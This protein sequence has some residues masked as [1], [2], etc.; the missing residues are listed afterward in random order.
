[1][2]TAHVERGSRGL[3]VE[4]WY[5]ATDEHAGRDVAE[6]T[7]DTY[8]LIPGLPAT[9]QNAVRDAA[10]RAGRRPLI[11]FSHGY[12]GHRRQS[13]FLCT[14]LASHGYVVAAVDHVGNTVLD[15]LQGILML[16]GGGT[17]PDPRA[18]LREFIEA[19]PADVSCTIDRLLEGV[20]GLEHL[21]D[22]ERIGMAGHSFGG[23]TTLA[24]TARDRRI[25]AALPLAPA[26]GA[27]SLPVEPLRETVD[28]AWGREV[29]TL[30]VVADRDSLLPL[31]GMED[32]FARTPSAKRMVV[33]QNADHM[34]FCDRVEEVHEMF[35]LMPQDPLFQDI[36][37][38]IRPI[39]ELCP[40]EHANLAV[41]GL[42]LAHMDAHLRGDE[43]AARFLAGDLQAALAA[44]GVS[45]AVH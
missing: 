26:G 32:L 37:A 23:W 16:Q 42:G 27:S 34:H 30:F 41:R 8:E 25:R 6:A 31:A 5:P 19:R 14:H 35:R 22:P 11:A 1:V 17:R 10:P 45:V 43:S 38:A 28:F 20:A 4:V 2:R 21:V 15:V 3:P 12:G 24:V 33:L 13:T 18:V 40:G 39:T 9:W 44:H 29:P 7:R 36:Q